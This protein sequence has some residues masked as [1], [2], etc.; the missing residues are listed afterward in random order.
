MYK[1][2]GLIKLGTQCPIYLNHLR[3]F[4]YLE[5]NKKMFLMKSVR[6]SKGSHDVVYNLFITFLLMRYQGH[7]HFLKSILYQD[8]W[9]ILHMCMKFSARKKATSGT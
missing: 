4:L 1:T 6:I 2:I 3:W 5:S 8:K 7:H 9:D